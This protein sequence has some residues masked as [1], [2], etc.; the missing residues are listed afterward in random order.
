MKPFTDVFSS[1]PPQVP[2]G[3][4]I[5]G[6]YPPRFRLNRGISQGCSVGDL[7]DLTDLVAASCW[8]CCMP[9][10]HAW[11]L[12]VLVGGRKWRCWWKN[13]MTLKYE[14]PHV[15]GLNMWKFSTKTWFLR[16][17]SLILGGKG[18]F[19]GFSW[20]M[21]MGYGWPVL[22]SICWPCHVVWQ[23]GFYQAFTHSEAGAQGGRCR[24]TPSREGYD[25]IYIYI[26]IYDHI[27]I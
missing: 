4:K 16:G 18:L 20:N 10:P 26:S 12:V 13:P 2:C 24:K 11:W 19:M 17:G 14:T 3:R 9:C 21:L 23:R 22:L 25:I 27:C 5:I 15:D 6:F 1:R 7:E 8:S